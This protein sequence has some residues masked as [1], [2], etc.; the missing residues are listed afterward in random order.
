M[1]KRKNRNM[2]KRMKKQGFIPH[3]WKERVFQKELFKGATLC[4]KDGKPW[5]L[6][7]FMDL[8]DIIFEFYGDFIPENI[9]INE[10]KTDFYDDHDRIKYYISHFN[11]DP[12]FHW[13]SNVLVFS[14]IPHAD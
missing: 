8:E 2:N 4:V 6:I 14:E 10:Y 9:I 7:V 11:L 13:R 12:Y 3:P 5:T 1:T